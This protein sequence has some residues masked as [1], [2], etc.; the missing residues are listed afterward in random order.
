MGF[1]TGAVRDAPS[2]FCGTRDQVTRELR[3]RIEQFATTYFIFAGDRASVD[4]SS[5]A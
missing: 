2:M 1:P 4:L 3:T 5:S